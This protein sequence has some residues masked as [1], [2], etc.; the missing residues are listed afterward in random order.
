[1]IIKWLIE[2][3][4]FIEVVIYKMERLLELVIGNGRIF[5][6]N[7]KWSYVSFPLIY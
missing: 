3:F 1:M 7:C 6:G 5:H 4:R 2:I